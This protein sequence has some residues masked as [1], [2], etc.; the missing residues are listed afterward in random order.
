MA[1]DIIFRCTDGKTVHVEYE[2]AM[3]AITIRDMLSD[4]GA[5][6]EIPIENYSSEI[7]KLAFDFCRRYHSDSKKG[8]IND[9]WRKQI[10]KFSIDERFTLFELVKAANWL[11]IP[12]LYQDCCKTCA[13]HIAGK[14]PEFMC[15]YFGV[16]DDMTAKEKEM[17]RKEIIDKMY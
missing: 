14:L 2:I 9:D 12:R 17:V 16:Q 13:D 4:C 3:M 6:R 15:M 8:K 1:A 5:I 11:N 7:I 10:L